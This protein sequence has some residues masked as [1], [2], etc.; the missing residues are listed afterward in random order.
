MYSIETSYYHLYNFMKIIYKQCS[1][2]KLSLHL[3]KCNQCQKFYISTNENIDYTNSYC[4]LK[5][6]L[7]SMLIVEY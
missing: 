7:N 6:Q 2:K 4:S 5:C 3:E 1:L